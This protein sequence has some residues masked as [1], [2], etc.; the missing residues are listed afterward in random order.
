[1]DDDQ[2]T[3]DMMFLDAEFV[4]L[5]ERVAGV[6]LRHDRPSLAELDRLFR[7]PL[8]DL[9]REDFQ[10]ASVMTAA[11]L[12]ETVRALG[13]GHWHKD[14]TLG[15]GLTDV[16]GVP[17]FLRVLKRAEKRISGEGDE[18]LMQFIERACPFRN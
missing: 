11:F 8:G 17:G 5:I 15:P 1:M 6:R 14:E 10:S 9:A 16:P 18:T 2:L 4:Q 13:G 12:G 7:G 3:R